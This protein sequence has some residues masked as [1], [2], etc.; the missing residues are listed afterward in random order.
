MKAD[1]VK[2]DQIDI[3][4][5]VSNL[6]EIEK[7]VNNTRGMIQMMQNQPKTVKVRSLK[8][9]AAEMKAVNAK[10][11][12]AG[13]NVE[14]LRKQMNDQERI[15][16]DLGRRYRELRQELEAAATGQPEVTISYF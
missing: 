8:Q 16:G 4:V 3:E 5:R 1:P 6:T 15:G 11:Q 10:A 14:A 9:I 2:A 13:K 7:F 12:R